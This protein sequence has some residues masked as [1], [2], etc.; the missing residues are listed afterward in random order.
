MDDSYSSRTVF[1]IEHH[2]ALPR[3][4]SIEGFDSSP[5]ARF[6]GRIKIRLNYYSVLLSM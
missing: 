6:F 1:Q 3:S 5:V 4:R 2:R